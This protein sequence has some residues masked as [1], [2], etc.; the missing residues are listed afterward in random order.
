MGISCQGDRGRKLWLTFE[1]VGKGKEDVWTYEKAQL[2]ES[3][4]KAT[5]KMGITFKEIN[6][7][8]YTFTP[9]NINNT[10]SELKIPDGGVLTIKLKSAF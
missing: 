3:L 4:K 9:L 7:I 1:C 8:T 5:K 10:I 2:R 6:E